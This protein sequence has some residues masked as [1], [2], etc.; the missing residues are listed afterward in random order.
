MYRLSLVY[1]CRGKNTVTRS[2]DG[3]VTVCI[4]LFVELSPIETL[5][6]HAWDPPTTDGEL[7]KVAHG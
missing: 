6:A 5:H 3:D 4:S 7:L 1:I 2:M